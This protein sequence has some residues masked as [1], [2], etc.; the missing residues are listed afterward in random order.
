MHLD[1]RSA[2]EARIDQ[3]AAL[4]V[5]LVTELIAEDE[6]RPQSV[7]DQVFDRPR[8]RPGQQ[9]VE[10]FSFAAH[11]PVELVVALGSNGDHGTFFLLDDVPDARCQGPRVSSADQFACAYAERTQKL[12]RFFVHVDAGGHQRPEE[13][14]LAGLIGPDVRLGLRRCLRGRR[15]GLPR[16]LMLRRR[17]PS[18]RLDDGYELV[19][20]RSVPGD[21]QLARLV[22]DRH[23]LTWS[24][25]KPDTP[26]FVR[27]GRL[28][29]GGDGSKLLSKTFLLAP[30]DR[31]GPGWARFT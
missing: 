13:V 25:R 23:R 26:G 8:V 3:Q 30:G 11:L 17:P 21:D 10:V 6:R 9:R 12:R 29:N 27:A 24:I 5:S 16:R 2:A 19:E 22:L 1:H 18:D 28:V 15:C 31:V 14:A 4:D 20:C 7:T